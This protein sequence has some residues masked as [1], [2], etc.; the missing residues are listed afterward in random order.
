MMMDRKA[1][2]A[3]SSCWRVGTEKNTMSWLRTF[4]L[5]WRRWNELT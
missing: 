5:Y 4:L 2:T 1:R 3:F